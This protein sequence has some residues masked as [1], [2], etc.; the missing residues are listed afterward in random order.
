MTD[1]V[2]TAHLPPLIVLHHLIVRSALRLPHEMHGWSEH[3]YVLWVDKHT[4]AE[5][6]ELLE[7][8]INDQVGV[9]SNGKSSPVKKGDGDDDEVE[10]VRL[11]REVL[12]HAREH[13]HDGEEHE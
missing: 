5:Q 6:W 11:V 7:N 3:E 10:T 2:E 1:P 4:E 12:V 13:A 8:A 9:A